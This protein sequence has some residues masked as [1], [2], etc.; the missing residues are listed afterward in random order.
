MQTEIRH[1]NGVRKRVDGAGDGWAKA[2]RV[3]LGNSFLMQDMDAMFG[4]LVFGKNTGDKLFLEYAPDAYAN[5]DKPFREFGL[6][7]MFD[8]KRSMKAV[9]GE[10]S[11]LSN[12]FYR[13]SCAKLSEGQPSP[14]RFFYVVGSD[15][16]P[17]QMIEVDLITG[18]F[19]DVYDVEDESN[20][21]AV[22]SALGLTDLRKAL[23]Q[24]LR[25]K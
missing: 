2:H 11:N 13:W 24:W 3:E 23:S 22:W 15:D 12:R 9:H 10:Q 17:W 5:K 14:A 18:E 16:P 4:N 19:G 7:A 6:V 1:S 20:W 25:S 8:R 21:V